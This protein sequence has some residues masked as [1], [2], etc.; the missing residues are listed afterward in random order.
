MQVAACYCFAFLLYFSLFISISSCWTIRFENNCFLQPH[1]LS[2]FYHQVII[3]G[4]Y[5]NGVHCQGLLSASMTSL[6]ASFSKCH[7]KTFEKLEL[8]LSLQCPLGSP[9]AHQL[10]N[11]WRKNGV[12]FKDRTG[13]FRDKRRQGYGG[14]TSLLQPKSIYVSPVVNC[15]Y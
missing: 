4:Y 12:F 15:L 3:A 9:S 2:K 14:P 11:P 8:S 5:T 1:K 6:V 13:L 7:A 10:A